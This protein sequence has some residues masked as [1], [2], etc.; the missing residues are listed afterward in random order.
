VLAGEPF[1]VACAAAAPGDPGVGALDDPAAGQDLEPGGVVAA[2][3]D[4]DD[5][6][7]GPQRPAGP[8]AVVG[9]V[10]PDELQEA[11]AAGAGVAEEAD[12][13]VAVLGVRGVMTTAMSRPRVDYDHGQAPTVAEDSPGGKTHK[14]GTTPATAT[15][16]TGGTMNGPYHYVLSEKLAKR[17]GDLV[18]RE[19]QEALVSGLIALAKIHA[20][21]AVAAAA[22]G[23]RDVLNDRGPGG[24]PPTAVPLAELS[25]LKPGQAEVAPGQVQCRPYT[26]RMSVDLSDEITAIA[27]AVLAA[28]AVITAVFAVL[29]FLK[30][31]RE[32]RAIERQVTDQ[33]ELT[34]QQG[35]LLKV[36]SGQLELQ[37]RQLDDQLAEKHRAQASRVFI[38]TETGPDPRL[39][40]A[41]IEKGVPW[42]ETVTAS[43]R[44]TSEQPIYSAEL[45]WD[46]GSA[47]LAEVAARSHAERLPVVLLPG[48]DATVTREV[49]PD[50]GAVIL[51]FRDAAG[52]TWL[53]GTEG[54]LV[55]LSAPFKGN[56]VEGSS[57]SGL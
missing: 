16:A 38:W 34:Q 20:T 15:P 18:S 5:D 31:S 51:R 26:S 42:R 44:N 47:P 53:R 29:A 45:V 7:Q 52:V 49:D 33:Q 54:D 19:G 1:V 17:A 6:A 56:E 12:G 27:T 50:T 3:D 9:A 30:Q 35:Q 46:D 40:D 11:A 25:T 36:Q 57:A 2:A 43:I 4:L 37:R 21:L 22:A 13:G 39:T 48:S 41:Q 14:R 10:G 55:D 8:A 23:G 24:P 32:V 28:F